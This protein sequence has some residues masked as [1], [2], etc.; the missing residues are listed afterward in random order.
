MRERDY[1]A[2]LIKKLK[3]MFP[4]CIVIKSPSDYIQGLPDLTILYNDKWA[5]LEVKVE[6]DAPSQ[7][8]QEHYVKQ[9][10]GMSFA[11][12]IYPENEERILNA[13]QRALTSKRPT[14]V[15]VSKQLP[16]D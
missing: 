8:N 2:K 3:V 7:P 11:A 4:G 13:L 15:S 16:L 12:F 9:A 6:E 14:R 10:N 5:M 1:Q